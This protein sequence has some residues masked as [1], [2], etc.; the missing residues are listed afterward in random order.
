MILAQPRA[1]S[2]QG[3]RIV[4]VQPPEISRRERARTLAGQT[5]GESTGLFVVPR[6]L[7][8]DDAGGRLVFERLP[9]TGLLDVLENPERGAATL[10][11]VA[12]CLAAIHRLM[13]VDGSPGPAYGRPLVAVHGDFGLT[14]VL[15]LAGS[16][17]LAVIDWANASWL[18]FSGELGPPELDVATFLVSLFHRRLFYPKQVASR[19]EVARHFLATYSSASPHGLDLGVLRAIVAADTPAFNRLTRQLRGPVRALGYR[20]AMVDLHWFLRRLARRKHP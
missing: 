13:Q 6:I 17:G 5:V 14:N 1:V 18:S 9:L 8:F 15:G 4:K 11:R 7:E 19:H 2:G 16:D 3:D 10:A 20:H 12:Q